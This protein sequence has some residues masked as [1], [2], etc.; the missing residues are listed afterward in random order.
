MPQTD[1]TI[2]ETDA[3][4][5]RA[6]QRDAGLSAD[7]LSDAVG[8]SRNAAWRRM[9]RM[10]DAGIIRKRVVLLDPQTVGRGLSVFA[11]IRTDRHDAQWAKTFSDVTRAMPEIIGVW[12]T[13]GELDYLLHI[14]VADVGGYDRL[15]RRLIEKIELK[16]VTASFVMEEIKETTE[17]PV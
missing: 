16:D 12:R 1:Q 11:A 7:A 13:S 6:L 17:L 14:R 5:L 10:E 8:L 15:Y 3:R 2:D 4:I 9:K